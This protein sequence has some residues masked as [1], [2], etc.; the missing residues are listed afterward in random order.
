MKFLDKAKKTETIYEEVY[1]I[2]V[3]IKDANKVI[4]YYLVKQ[5]CDSI[6]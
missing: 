1:I 5:F 3:V 4:Y 6:C 2:L